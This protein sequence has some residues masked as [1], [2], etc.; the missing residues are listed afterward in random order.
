MLFF[1]SKGFALLAQIPT[2]S[3]IWMLDMMEQNGTYSFTNAVNITHREG[4]DNQPVF[5]PDGSYILYTSIR[6]DNQADIYK[7]DIQTKLTLQLTKTP[8]SEYSPTFTPDKNFIS[9]VRVEKDST[10]RLWKFNIDGTNPV[11]INPDIDSV[12]YHCWINN[13]TFAAFILTH[14][15]SLRLSNTI[16]ANSSI[17]STNVGR[18]IHLQDEENI[19]FTRDID[20]V[21]WI[22]SAGPLQKIKPVI[23]TPLGSEDFEW[24]KNGIILIAKGSLLYKFDILKDNDWKEIANLGNYNINNITRIAVNADCTKIAL[25]GNK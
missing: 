1:L 5:S 6:E 7:Y 12:G 15:F 25:V 23:K 17:L 18:S 19:V 8:E 24:L 14:P 3:E 9:T 16:D 20:S 13:T 4:Y 10:Q 2:G 22:C 21:K 11:L